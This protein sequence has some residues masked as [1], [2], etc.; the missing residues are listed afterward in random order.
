MKIILIKLFKI[1]LILIGIEVL[2][3]VV[4]I[5][6]LMSDEPTNS[7]GRTLYLGL[8]YVLGF[9]LVLINENYPFFLDSKKMPNEMI[10]LV[11][12]NNFIQAGII[13]WVKSLLKK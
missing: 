9:P 2:L 5:F 13:V 11:L 6:F 1:L 10:P 7:V 3:F 8:K 4:M 12:L